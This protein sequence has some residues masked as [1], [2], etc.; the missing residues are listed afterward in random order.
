M[1]RF[2]G[3][4]IKRIYISLR[5][6]FNLV[7]HNGRW[8]GNRY[9]TWMRRLAPKI[10]PLLPE[11][12]FERVQ[13]TF[14]ETYNTTAHQGLKNEGFDPPVPIEVLG[15]AKGRLYTIEELSQKFFRALFPA[16]RTNMAVSPCT[17]IISMSKRESPRRAFYCGSMGS[18]CGR[19]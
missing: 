19:C 17:V 1:S 12:Q 8:E 5:R 7:R 3:I 14:M 9:E 16:R 15:G 18:N 4:P 2:T 11:G 13:Q 6:T 10:S